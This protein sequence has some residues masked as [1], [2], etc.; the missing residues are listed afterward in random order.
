MDDVIIVTEPERY[1]ECVRSRLDSHTSHVATGRQGVAREVQYSFGREWEEYDEILPEHRK[2]FGQY[3][4]LIEAG[5]L[6]DSHVCDLGCGNGRWSYFL[7]DLCKEIILVDFSDAIF[8]ARRNLAS[9]S[10]CLFFMGDLQS[11]PFKKDFCELVFCLGVLHHL[12]VPCIEAVRGLQHCAPRLLI[13]LYYSYENRPAYFR[14]LLHL[15][16]F[17]R[18]VLCRIQHAGFRTYCSRLMTLVLYKPLILLGYMLRPLQLS[19]YVP[20]YEF[21]HDKSVR[22]IEQ[23]V[24]DRFFTPIEQR[25]SRKDILEL[26]DSFSQITLSNSLPYWHFLCVR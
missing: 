25:V 21:Y 14:F 4:D 12:P 23:D 1:T 10:N 19:R 7:K 20:L 22:R 5:S 8:V 11:L 17:S 3:F 26:S 15:V 16:T 24:Y 13:F 18:R 6:R 2:E 9:S